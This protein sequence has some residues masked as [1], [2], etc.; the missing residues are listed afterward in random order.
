MKHIH[1]GSIHQEERVWNMIH[2]EENGRIKMAMKRRNN[3]NNVSLEI[4]MFPS[5]FFTIPG[6]SS[7]AWR[8]GLGTAH[9]S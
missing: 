1:S 2:L 9:L 8:L 5:G 7:S 6:T 4:T 3:D